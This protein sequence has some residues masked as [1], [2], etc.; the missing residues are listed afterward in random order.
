MARLLN[1]VAAFPFRGIGGKPDAV[2]DLK[3][4]KKYTIV[5]NRIQECLNLRLFVTC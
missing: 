1:P 2:Y 5:H 4:I 3:P